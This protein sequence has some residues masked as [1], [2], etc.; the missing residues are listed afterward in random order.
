[1]N[2]NITS[3][4]PTGNN[5]D[6]GE[7]IAKSF[8]AKILGVVGTVMILQF[9]GLFVMIIFRDLFLQ[10]EIDSGRKVHDVGDIIPDIMREWECILIFVLGIIL[11]R[12]SRKILKENNSKDKTSRARIETMEEVKD[13]AREKTDPNFNETNEKRI[14]S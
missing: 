8:V 12:I 9:I 14:D 5:A 4:V 1:M 2:Y 6:T 3:I 10:T 7:R 13:I 11:V